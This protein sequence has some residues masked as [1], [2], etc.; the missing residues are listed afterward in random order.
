MI[1]LAVV[2]VLPQTSQVSAIFYFPARALNRGSAFLFKPV[3]K[4][5]LS[6]VYGLGLLNDTRFPQTYVKHRKLGRP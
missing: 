6:F 2:T 5:A 1:R 3:R 4:E